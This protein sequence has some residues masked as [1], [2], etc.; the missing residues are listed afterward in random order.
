MAEAIALWA[1]KVMAVL[2]GSVFVITMWTYFRPGP[3]RRVN[4]WMSVLALSCVAIHL[5]FLIATQSAPLGASLAA[6]GLFSV[7]LGLFASAAVAHGE[8]RPGVVFGERIPEGLTT[9]GVYRVVRHPFYLAY[10]VGFLGSTMIG[11]HWLLLATT[12]A[13]FAIYNKAAAG[14]ERYLKQSPM[15]GSQYQQ[16]CDRTWR[17]LPFVW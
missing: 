6:I 7:A 5:G 17:W 15:L 12:L 3:V 10:I 11:R 1:A 16:Y 4:W 8:R 14:E 9:G 2:T 13:L